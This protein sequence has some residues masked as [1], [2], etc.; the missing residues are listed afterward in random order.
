MTGFA[1]EISH[2]LKEQLEGLKELGIRHLELRN[3]WGKNVLDLTDED[4]AK[5]NFMLT[6]YGA[7]VSSIASPLGKS[8]LQ[9]DFAIQEQGMRRAIE[10]C[11]QLNT[12]Y[13]R[14]FSF[15]IPEGGS[16]DDYKD[17]VISR[18]RRF[19]TMAEQSGVVIVLENDNGGLYG[20]TDE[21]VLHIVK[22]IHSPSL[23]LAFDSGNFVFAGVSAKKAYDKLAPYIGYVHIKDADATKGY[24]VE[25]GEGEG[26]LSVL[27][28]DLKQSSYE[29]FL[30]IEPHLHNKYPDKSDPERFAI[31]ARALQKMLDEQYMSWN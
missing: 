26:E 1:D 7:A 10:L 4:V 29:G 19:V 12:K 3:V 24:F 13:I 6:E 18:M 25:A 11:K 17:D 21:R 28:E 5:V 2:D 15:Y 31:A 30:S 23:K 14:M 22:E 8:P 16:P 27:L 9:S 20:D